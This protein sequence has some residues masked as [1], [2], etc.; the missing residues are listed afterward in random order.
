MGGGVTYTMIQPGDGT[1][2]GLRKQSVPGAPS[3]W[4]AY[5]LVDDV[6]AATEKAKS[7]GAKV[8]KDATKCRGWAGSASS[9]TRRAR[10]SGSG[11]RRG[12]RQTVLDS[13]F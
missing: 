13:R 7:L 8:L 11:R 6:K 1:G 2:G 9:P 5:V 10:R 4:L 12:V 3:A